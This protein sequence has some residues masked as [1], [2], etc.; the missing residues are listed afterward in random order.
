MISHPI[1]PVSSAML[2][3]EI[4]AFPF[5]SCKLLLGEKAP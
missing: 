1:A 5:N 2:V 4:I 3:P